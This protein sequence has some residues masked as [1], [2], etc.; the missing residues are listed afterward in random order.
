MNKGR[1]SGDR[2]KLKETY[3]WEYY[4]TIQSGEIL[5]GQDL[6][7]ELENLLDD[8]SKPEY[9][10]NIADA[11]TRI[12]FIENCV[13][14]TKSPFYNKPMLLLLWQKAY[15]EALYSFKM[16][17]VDSGGGWVRRF[18]ESL[19]LITR[20]CG[21][22]ELIAALQFSELVLGKQGSDI[23]C[24]GTND[25]T[26]DLAYQAIDTMR[27]LV[28]P[29]SKDT[30]RN[31]KGIKCFEN[32]NHIYKLSDSTR[33]KEGRNID[34][35][36]IDEVWSLVD[37]GIYKPIQQSTSTKDESLVVM[38]GSEGF[39]DGG[40]LDT[41]REEYRKIIYGED[42]REVSKRKLP[43][44]YSMDDE[45]EVW[46]TDENGISRAWEK[47]NPSIG[48]VKKWSYLRDRVDEARRS[49]ADRAFTLA[50]DF[51]FKVSNSQAW[52]MAE[53]LEYSATFDLESMRGSIALAGVDLAETTDMS[54]AK[55]LMM[56]P[57]DR[58]KYILSMYWIPESKLESSDD[59][60]AGA[61]YAEWAKA[62]LL[63]IVEGNEVDT[64][65]IA[66]WF[67]E[68]Y[69]DYGIRLFMCGYDQRF[70]KSFTK[71]MDD[72]GF[73]YE[74]VYQNRFV[75]SSP[76]R[77]V[78]ADLKD[79]LVNYNDNPIDKWCLT[80]TAIKVWD[81]GHILAV[82]IK[83]QAARRIDGTLSLVMA[84]EMLRRYRSEFTGAMR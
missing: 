28:D 19:L 76:M 79:A 2:P 75:L 6:I 23:V 37:D 13:R 77:L 55:I 14:L 21:K 1:Y 45:L 20:K 39:V 64:A 46:Q 56:K 57:D 80:N 50:K 60:E 4:K 78:E 83:G 18:I 17:T 25:G 3:L 9:R 65:L 61:K 33:Q 67:V 24:S 73:D 26:A 59:K 35:A 7:A 36:G 68:L 82:K 54:S 53:D 41:K 40:F 49:K 47:A 81:T 43:W 27:L 30:W 51:N 15:I 16:R 48:A 58:T 72:Y 22:T 34:I 32:N 10:Y 8:F 11:F 84:Y 69:R 42:T 70:A 12:D 62:G 74:M 52:L 5:A 31:Q 66:D 71:R 44:I 63:R 38:F 29:K